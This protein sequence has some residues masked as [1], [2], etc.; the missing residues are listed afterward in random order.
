[1]VSVVVGSVVVVMVMVVPAILGMVAVGG[2]DSDPAEGEGDAGR[3]DRQCSGSQVAHMSFSYSF[4]GRQAR[5]RRF[6]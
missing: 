4:E 6:G 3:E 5:S 2:C 1:V